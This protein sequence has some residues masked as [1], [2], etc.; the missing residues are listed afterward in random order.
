[1]RKLKLFSITLLSVFIFS[2]CE[3]HE[4]IQPK[5]P[6]ELMDEVITHPEVVSYFPS[7]VQKFPSYD[8]GNDDV[9]AL[10]AISAN[11]Y[12]DNKDKQKEI[13]KALDAVWY[14]ENTSLPKW[15]ESHYDL[16]YEPDWWDYEL[17]DA[18]RR[19]VWCD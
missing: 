3:Y 9:D 6:L 13:I 14:R 17:V 10:A 11:T 15:A 1:M 12:G 4:V 5:E 19:G 18:V 2:G 7:G 16:Y 8:W